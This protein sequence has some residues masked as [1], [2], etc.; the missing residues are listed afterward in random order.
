M[1]SRKALPLTTILAA[2][3][4]LALTVALVLSVTA[5]GDP[6]ALVFCAA[7]ALLWVSG[8]RAA[9]L[10]VRSAGRRRVGGALPDDRPQS[11]AELRVALLYC[12]ADDADLTAMTIS[13]R[14]DVA[15]DAVILDDSKDQR[16]RDLI[17]AFAAAHGCQVIRR[18]ERTGF[19]AGNLN[20]GVAVLQGRYDAYVI[21]D[22]DVVLPP[23][24]VRV[25][26]HALAD[27]SVAVAQGLPD[28][29]GGRTWFARYF[30][31]LLATHVGVT[32]RGREAHGIVAFLGRGAVVRA[33]AI[34]EV[35]GFPIAVAED[36]AL[37]TALRRHGWRLVNV[38]VSFREDYPVDYRSFRTQARKTAEG[39]VEFLRHPRRL[40]GLPRWERFDALL[41][42]SLV[43]LTA[44]AG[45]T[46][47]MSG[48]A[49]ASRGTA[50]PLWA[51]MA[52]ALSALAPLLP[53]AVKRVRTQKLAA[54]MAFIALG[55][56]LY[57]SSM[58]VILGAVLRTLA[59]G[60]A[61][62]WITPKTAQQ[63]GL[64]QALMHLRPELV[65][66]PPL[67]V[68]TV[69]V[70]GGPLSAAGLLWP[71]LA[72]VAF[73]L[74]ALRVTR[75]ART[76]EDVVRRRPRLAILRRAGT[77]LLYRPSGGR[78]WKSPAMSPLA[79]P[80]DS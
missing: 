48:S 18:A 75:Q 9:A 65:L 1:T 33:S 73:F 72:S 42:A 59:G 2:A 49:L 44:L 55:G 39:A 69:L 26:A 38:D 70:S 5:G 41:E 60:R 11:G 50:P 40:R 31:P 78:I 34:D 53:E 16:S 15:V 63:L 74:P 45:V 28:A 56:A 7:S 32:R 17:D 12:V 54:G 51:I 66:A 46:A 58:F 24:F 8:W 77:R 14:Q 64:R 76:W 79:N 22:S 13:M 36:L 43:P 27:P 10:W 23:H 20:H 67:I 29:S 21:C 52:T 35:G 6:A 4:W 62:F 37:T 3:V 47:L 61:V 80:T 68:A 57:A 19:K 25:G 30:G 71:L